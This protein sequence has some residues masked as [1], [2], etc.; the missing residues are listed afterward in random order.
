M[1]NPI[2]RRESHIRFVAEQDG[3][4]ERELKSLLCD[5]FASIDGVQRAYLVRVSYGHATVPSVALALVAEDE[6]KEKIVAAI[7][8]IFDSMFNV[9]QHLDVLF[10]SK[11][12]ES[13]ISSVCHPF[14]STRIDH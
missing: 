2:S 4:P 5:L 3:Q 9:S 13:E 6:I 10:A 12:Q 14:F 1:L 11:S 8:G 7:S